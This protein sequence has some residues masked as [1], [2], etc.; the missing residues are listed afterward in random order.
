MWSKKSL[1]T[2]RCFSRCC[3]EPGSC[4]G[5]PDP[6]KPQ[7]SFHG[8]GIVADPR[9]TSQLNKAVLIHFEKLRKSEIAFS[10]KQSEH[11]VLTAEYWVISRIGASRPLTCPRFRNTM[12]TKLCPNAKTAKMRTCNLRPM[13]TWP[14]PLV[15]PRWLLEKECVMATLPSWDIVERE[16]NNLSPVLG[17]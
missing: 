11:A 16:M 12:R 4:A 14:G 8:K 7:E 17:R 15:L 2:L 9:Q 5:Q 10:Q 1:L 3:S 13:R 6:K